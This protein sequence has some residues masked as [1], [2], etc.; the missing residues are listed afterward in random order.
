V[1]GPG[2]KCDS[3]DKAVILQQ[4]SPGYRVSDELPDGW[5]RLGGPAAPSAQAMTPRYEFCSVKCV[6]AWTHATIEAQS[7]AAS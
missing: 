2:Y 6:A 5:F 4:D 1:N 7:A 3:C